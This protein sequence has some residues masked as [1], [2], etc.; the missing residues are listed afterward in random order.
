[1]DGLR[2]EGDLEA[3]AVFTPERLRHQLEQIEHRIALTGR[4]ARVIDFPRRA[5]GATMTSSAVKAPARWVAAAAAAGLFVG[6]V[7]GAGYEWRARATVAPRFA[8][9]ARPRLAPVATRGSSPANVAEDDAFLS[10]LEVALE[11]PHTRELQAFDAFT[12]R[13]HEV[14]A[15]R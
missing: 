10:D 13:V 11:S 14:R 6:V 2:R 9:S 4:H 3:D 8:E 1:M 12:P 5:V 7:V 15:E